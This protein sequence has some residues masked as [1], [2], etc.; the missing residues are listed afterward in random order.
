MH[1]LSVSRTHLQ[2]NWKTSNVF[3]PPK[4]SLLSSSS[5]LGGLLDSAATAPLPF[6]EG[7]AVDCRATKASTT[8]A[9]PQLSPERRQEVGHRRAPTPPAPPTLARHVGESIPYQTPAFPYP[10]PALKALI[11]PLLRSHVSVSTPFLWL[12]TVKNW[13]AVEILD[14]PCKL[15]KVPVTAAW[16]LEDDTA[17]LGQR[18]GTY[19]AQHGRDGST[20]RPGS[21][22][23]P[24]S[25]AAGM[26]RRPGVRCAGSGLTLRNPEPK[27]PESF[28]RG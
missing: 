2:L 7:H 13:E 19:H 1:L 15:T 14:P 8:Q 18:R 12:K 11:L 25:H 22:A 4:S 16:R 9:T 26:G 5:W 23:A 3:H 20:V 28:I 17:V 21:L 27:E 24:T 6:G 10:S